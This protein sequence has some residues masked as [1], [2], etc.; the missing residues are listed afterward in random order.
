[1]GIRTNN[2]HVPSALSASRGSPP[3]PGV[4]TFPDPAGRPGP[5]TAAQAA[6]EPRTGCGPA[7]CAVCDMRQGK[8]RRDPVPA[9]QGPLEGPGGPN[10]QVS[11]PSQPLRQVGLP[12]H[13][14]AH[15]CWRF[16]CRKLQPHPSELVCAAGRTL[17][18]GMGA[19]QADPCG[20]RGPQER[21]QHRP[22]R[23]L[24]SAPGSQ[25]WGCT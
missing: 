4:H 14:P 1:M 20:P 19:G 15:T 13:L 23:T 8:I 7:S 12:S 17:D 2:R 16:R 6:R 25:A 3:A 21:G 5:W 10:I 9:L 24:D 18:T 11:M 22:P